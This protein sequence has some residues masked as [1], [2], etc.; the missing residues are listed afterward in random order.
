MHAN[1]EGRGKASTQKL[2]LLDIV[3]MITPGLL[4]K[5]REHQFALSVMLTVALVLGVPCILLAGYNFMTKMLTVFFFNDPMVKLSDRGN[6]GEIADRTEGKSSGGFEKKWASSI[7]A[8]EDLEILRNTRTEVKST[9]GTAI[10]SLDT[11]KFVAPAPEI[12]DR[13][14]LQQS[15]TLS[16]EQWRDFFDSSTARLTDVKTLNTLQAVYAMHKRDEDVQLVIATMIQEVFES[17][18]VDGDFGT[19]RLYEIT[20]AAP[21]QNAA[22]ETCVPCTDKKV[23]AVRKMNRSFQITLVRVGKELRRRR[24]DSL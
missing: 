23:E 24:R 4:E 22:H 19:E 6:I 3:D 7:E 10:T 5:A 16:L 11:S 20:I 21:T 8:K 2:G 18:G 12:S 13:D 9:P 14:K 17:F 15:G 1:A